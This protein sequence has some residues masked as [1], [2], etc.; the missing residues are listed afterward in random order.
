MRMPLAAKISARSGTSA[1]G[2]RTFNVVS[3]GRNGEVQKRPALVFSEGYGGL[4]S[5]LIDSPN[6]LMST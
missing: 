2:A 4:G 6:G 5:G 3:D 1:R